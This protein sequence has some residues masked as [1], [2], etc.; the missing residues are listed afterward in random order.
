[1]ILLAHCVVTKTAN[2]T[3]HDDDMAVPSDWEKKGTTTTSSDNPQLGH[4]DDGRTLCIHSL[5]V[6][7]DYQGQGLGSTLLRAFIQRIDGS[8][9]ADR[10]TLLAHDSLIKFYERFGFENKGPSKATFAGGN[11][12]DM[13]ISTLFP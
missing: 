5:A 13:V 12:V 6:L 3:I 9:V 7:P 10:I 1:M 11:W 4:R 2:E 8:G